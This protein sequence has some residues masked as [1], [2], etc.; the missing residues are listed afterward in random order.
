M[1]FAA[2]PW[3]LRLRPAH[4]DEDDYADLAD[5]PAPDREGRLEELVSA[6]H[7]GM[8]VH[9]GP[10]RPAASFRAWVRR[11]RIEDL[12][13]VDV[14]CDPCSGI[15]GRRRAARAESLYLGVTIVRQGRETVIAGDATA[16]LRPGNAVVWRSDQPVRFRVHETQIKR[17]LLIPM[18]ALSEISGGAGLLRTEALD[19]AAPSTQL[20][21]GYLD[22]LARTMSRL[23][24]PAVSAA[25]Q[26]ALELF[27]AAVR[28]HGGSAAG[29][30]VF[31]TLAALENWIEKRLLV[32]DVTP[33]AI[34]A[35]HGMSVRSVYRIFEEA[36]E[37]VSGFVRARRLARA[38]RDLA[39]GTDP[40]SDI[41]VR[42]GFSDAS[43]F[44]RAFRAQYGCAPRD[45]RAAAAARR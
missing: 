11:R 8:D 26:A 17:T 5:V 7:V 19:G 37:T 39:A 24:A 14:G 35:A 42:W 6:T 23:T 34:A 21:T 13:L 15:R 32:G 10:E 40:I 25:R 41:A 20:L 22:V 18:A 29:A 2:D 45:Y 4:R 38:C 28:Q 12:V 27:A 1:D 33:A 9:L 36:D 16:D 30:T 44:A 31:P 43:H 3:H